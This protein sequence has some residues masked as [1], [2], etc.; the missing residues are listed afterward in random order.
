MEVCL[1]VGIGPV[2]ALATVIWLVVRLAR[3]PD[4]MGACATGVVLGGLAGMPPGFV[5][6]L[7]AY[8]AL[9]KSGDP[10]GVTAAIIVAIFAGAA[11]GAAGGAVG[12]YYLARWS[13]LYGFELVI[14]LSAL[15]LGALGLALSGVIASLIG[16]APSGSAE[17]AIIAVA[18]AATAGWLGAIAG[19]VVGRFRSTEAA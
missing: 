8:A 15:G 1:V 3:E 19:A 16:F 7:L 6:A 4:T 5:V 2:V 11:L 12:G 14:L 17:R 10:S 18:V 13:A 9:D